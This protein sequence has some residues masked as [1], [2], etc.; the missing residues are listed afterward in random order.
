MIQQ[1]P[2]VELLKAGAN[3]VQGMTYT[4]LRGS[5]ELLHLQ[6]SSKTVSCNTDML[7]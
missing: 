7:V 1:N 5:K 2:E 6:K 3:A 4:C